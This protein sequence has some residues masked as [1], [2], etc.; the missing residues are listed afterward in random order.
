MFYYLSQNEWLHMS[1][2]GQDQI[3]F[4]SSLGEFKY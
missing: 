2:S 4:E 3:L 1:R